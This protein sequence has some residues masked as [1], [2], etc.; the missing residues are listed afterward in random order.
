LAGGAMQLPEKVGFNWQSV[1]QSA[2]LDNTINIHEIVSENSEIAADL[3]NANA[4]Y[5]YWD[6][7]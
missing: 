1:L 6:K 5:E 7:A 4:A 3:K 2:L